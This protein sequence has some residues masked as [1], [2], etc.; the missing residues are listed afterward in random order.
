MLPTHMLYVYAG[1]QL[2]DLPLG[3][4]PHTVYRGM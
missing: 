1:H 3:Q 2:R 4:P